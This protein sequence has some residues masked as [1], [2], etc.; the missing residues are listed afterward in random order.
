MSMFADNDDQDDM[1]E[2]LPDGQPLLI[3]RHVFQHM[4]HGVKLLQ[5][6]LGHPDYKS[7]HLAVYLYPS[8]QSL[9]EGDRSFT[10]FSGFYLS[11][12]LEY[13]KLGRRI[14]QALGVEDVEE[15]EELVGR[16][17]RFDV[18]WQPSRRPGGRR[19]RKI[20]PLPPEAAAQAA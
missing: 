19:W 6:I 5:V 14:C 15:P 11:R 10:W 20:E 9:V 2:P 17:G 8:D 13:I 3:V 1:L 4:S 12:R 18:S 16:C 7:V